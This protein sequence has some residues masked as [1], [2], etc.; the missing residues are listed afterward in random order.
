[1]RIVDS[2]NLTYLEVARIIDEI[3]NKGYE[4]DQLAIRV[5]EYVNKF[6]KCKDAQSLVKE[7]LEAGLK[8]ITA[9]MIANIVP[10]NDDEVKA[11]LNFE[12]ELH[13]TEAVKKILEEV[14]AH[15]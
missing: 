2:R 11:L 15:C 6:S 14:K 3:K 7:L 13:D 1:M 9:V 8:E 5:S 4:L 12:H 10:Q